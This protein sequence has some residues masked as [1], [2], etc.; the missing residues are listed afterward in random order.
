MKM[1][2]LALAAPIALLAACGSI[3]ATSDNSGYLYATLR[4]TVKRAS[5]AAVP[6]A[7]VGV[8][9]SG[10]TAD[11]FGFTVEANANGV[12][13]LSLNAAPSFPPL[14]GPSYICR[15]LTPFTGLAQAEKSV[16][17]IV[18]GDRNARPVTN[19]ELVVP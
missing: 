9:C 5:G 2:R 14:A 10:I 13:E 12:F 19:V 4:G 6:N 7:A 1:F 17:V 18:S 11:P 3:T 16:T 15:V 8:S